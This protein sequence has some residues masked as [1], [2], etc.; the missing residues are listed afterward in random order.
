M[1]TT[2]RGDIGT[3][4]YYIPSWRLSLKAR[5]RAPRTIETYLLAANQLVDFLTE[6][7]MPLELDALKREHVESY[8]E[9][10]VDNRSAATA[11]QRFASL[12]QLMKFLEEE[13]EV[14][15][16]PMARMKK[17]H[18]PE[19]PIPVLLDDQIR[20]LLTACKGDT[21]EDLRDMAVVRMFLDTGMRLSELANLKVDDVDHTDQQVAFIVAKGRRERAVPFGDKTG[22]AIDRYLRRGR[23]R[24]RLAR[25]E[26][27][28]LSY[29][30]R[31][32]NS[33]IGQ[34]LKRRAEDAG[35]GHLHPHQFRH[36]FAHQWLANGGQE[37]DLQRIVGWKDRQMLA[38]YGAS[39]AEERAREA[40]RRMSPGDRY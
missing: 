29:K 12:Q 9:W 7:G 10:L 36:T 2:T 16:S 8:I 35:I 6:R 4:P 21:F 19:K 18:I 13:G 40:H 28:W 27:L 37:G 30:G 34:M 38:R 39:A 14:T 25:S 23:A 5:N 20:A 31:F 11:A 17:P 1:D 26:W 24:H 33:G 32:T 3:L 15:A 22:L